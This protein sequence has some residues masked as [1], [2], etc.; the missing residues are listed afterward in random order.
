[1]ATIKESARK[2]LSADGE[3]LIKSDEV[4]K[5]LNSGVDSVYNHQSDETVTSR[6]NQ[7]ISLAKAMELADGGQTN[8]INNNITDPIVDRLKVQ[9]GFNDSSEVIF[10]EE[11]APIKALATAEGNI[12]SGVISHTGVQVQIN[13]VSGVG[14]DQL[15]DA[16]VARNAMDV[17]A[18]RKQNGGWDAAA[19]IVIRTENAS[20]L[21]QACPYD[22]LDTWEPELGNG[23]A[24]IAAGLSFEVAKKFFEEAKDKD[25]KTRMDI[26]TVCT[27]NKNAELLDQIAGDIFVRDLNLDLGNRKDQLV[28]NQLISIFKMRRGT[29]GVT[30]N[31]ASC[32]TL[33]IGMPHSRYSLSDSVIW[34]NENKLKHIKTI[35]TAKGTVYMASSYDYKQIFTVPVKIDLVPEEVLKDIAKWEQMALRYGANQSRH[36]MGFPIKPMDDDLLQYLNRYNTVL[37][38]TVYEA[39]GLS[40]GAN[41]IAKMDLLEKTEI[42]AGLIISNYK[43]SIFTKA[44]SAIAAEGEGA[45]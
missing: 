36:I 32:T 13:R 27:R 38:P 30:A 10:T 5:K 29:L 3:K 15:E 35:T 8:T 4:K 16:V 43:D 26:L 17:F 9:L 12:V 11:V 2:L 40:E 22:T 6:S 7:S 34:T 45:V 19:E 44:A 28:Y 31:N 18:E 42:L 23:L 33:T 14:G 1:M 20:G 24:K 37:R 25:E 39:L 41:Q 21:R